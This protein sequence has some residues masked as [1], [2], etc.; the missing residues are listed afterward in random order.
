VSG[1]KDERDF[2][3]VRK[4]S[5]HLSDALGRM[6]FEGYNPADIHLRD[7]SNDYWQI[8]ALPEPSTYGAMLGAVGLGL[9]CRSKRRR[10]H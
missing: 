3:L 10:N 8:S 5:A 2:L 6:K 7:F 1:W 4:N 9:C